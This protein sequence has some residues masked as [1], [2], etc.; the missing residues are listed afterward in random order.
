MF[1]PRFAR[2]LHHPTLAVV[3]GAILVVVGVIGLATG[4]MPVGWAILVVVVGMVNLLR[5]VVPKEARASTEAPHPE[6]DY[7]S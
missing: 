3:L 6:R 4:N 2:A 5:G 7:S 1:L